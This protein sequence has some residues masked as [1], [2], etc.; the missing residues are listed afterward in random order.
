MDQPNTYEARQKLRA[1]LARARAK[2]L[3]SEAQDATWWALNEI[4]DLVAL[5][6]RIERAGGL[7]DGLMADLR[8]TLENHKPG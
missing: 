8:A 1:Y 6:K 2:G 4:D 7:P 5:L 3:L